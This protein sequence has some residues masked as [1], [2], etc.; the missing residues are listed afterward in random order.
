MKKYRS[1]FFAIGW[2]SSVA[3][4]QLACTTAESEPTPMKEDRMTFDQALKEHFD[5]VMNKQLD[6]YAS[7]LATDET[8]HMIYPDGEKV[9]VL[10]T[11]VQLHRDWFARDD[12]T[13]EYDIIKKDVVGDLAYA[14][15]DI[16]YTRKGEDGQDNLIEFYL[17]VIFKYKND[18]WVLVHDQNTLH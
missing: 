2:I 9:M 10:D 18:K 14:L 4:F 3:F 6:A 17:N 11:I 7:T 16:D 12:W 8:L 13:F 5:A 15:L 1:L